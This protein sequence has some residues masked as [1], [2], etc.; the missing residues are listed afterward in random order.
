MPLYISAPFPYMRVL[1]LRICP[2]L[3]ATYTVFSIATHHALWFSVAIIALAH[4]THTPTNN[5]NNRLEH[6]LNLNTPCL[7]IESNSAR[8]SSFLL[9]PLS[10]RQLYA[11][12]V[13]ITLFHSTALV[14]Q[15]RTISPDVPT[16][17]GLQPLLTRRTCS[18]IR[19]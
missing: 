3:I 17:V 5:L 13:I 9:R 12:Y 6:V 14:S 7:G 2:A 16:S 11:S 10:L 18:T 8:L 19:D 1:H 15:L 4:S